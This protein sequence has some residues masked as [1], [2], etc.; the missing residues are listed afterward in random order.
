M[1]RSAWLTEGLDRYASP[2]MHERARL[3]LL[4]PVA[5]IQE[6][7]GDL[8]FLALAAHTVEH[9]SAGT[10][11]VPESTTLQYRS[12]VPRMRFTVNSMCAAPPVTL[13]HIPCHFQLGHLRVLPLSYG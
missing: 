13:S 11:S 5:E 3:V 6:V 8:I 2:P 12:A 4:L 9:G 1:Q 7:L 10:E